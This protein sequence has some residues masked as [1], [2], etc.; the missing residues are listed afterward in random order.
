MCIY[1]ALCASYKKTWKW[2]EIIN[3][4]CIKAPQ[5]RAINMPYMQYVHM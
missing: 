2:K 1:R 5:N 3:Y 4:K